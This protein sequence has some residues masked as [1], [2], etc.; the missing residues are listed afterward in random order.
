MTHTHSFGHGL[1][2]NARGVRHAI[3]VRRESVAFGAYRGERGRAWNVT[4]PNNHRKDEFIGTVFVFQRLDITD[5]DLDLLAGKNVGDR[6]R[7]DVWTLLIQQAGCLAV[8]LGGFIDGLGFFAPQDL[9]AHRAISHDHGHIID[10]SI[11]GQRKRVDCFDLFSER[12]FKLLSD[13]H[14]RQESADLRSGAGVL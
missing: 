5:R 7:K 3:G 4:R 2:R 11:L 12:I 10:S 9:S 6:L 8:G 14:A 1:R 13:Y